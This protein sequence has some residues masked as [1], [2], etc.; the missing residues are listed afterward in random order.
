MFA[1]T[2]YPTLSEHSRA[3]FVEFPSQFNEHWAIY[4]EVFSHYARHYK[5]GE[6]LPEA[7]A[8]KIKKAQ[9]FNVGYG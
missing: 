5:T 3:D 2:R 6:A 4:P 1:N 8:A 7:L 9:N